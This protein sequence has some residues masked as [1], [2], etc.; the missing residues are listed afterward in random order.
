MQWC[1]QP[2]YLANAVAVASGCNVPALVLAG[3]Y[4]EGPKRGG[5]EARAKREG[6]VIVE[7]GRARGLANAKAAVVKPCSGALLGDG[8]RSAGLVCHLFH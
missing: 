7:A 8:V 3:G 4:G 6:R 2:A 1:V 5:G